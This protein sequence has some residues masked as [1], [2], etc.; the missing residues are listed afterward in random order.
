MTASGVAAI[1][2]SPGKSTQRA[3]L[4]PAEGGGVMVLSPTLYKGD[5]RVQ[6]SADGSTLV[7]V[8]STDPKNEAVVR[9]YDVDRPARLTPTMRPGTQ[10]SVEL[11]LASTE[12]GVLFL[13]F[14]EAQKPL[15]LAGISGEFAIDLSKGLLMLYAGAASTLK[16]PF[17]IPNDPK[18]LGLTIYVQ[19]M[20]LLTGQFKGSFPP[21]LHIDITP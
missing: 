14:A 1:E 9:R 11:P 18:L 12:L 15:K 10:G 4:V 13:G 16:G 19:P 8:G 20:R 7:Y 5:G 17:V 3:A 2:F 6:V 21:M